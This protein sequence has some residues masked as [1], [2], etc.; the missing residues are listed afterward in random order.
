MRT[1]TGRA[2]GHLSSGPARSGR[3][4]PGHNIGMRKT[5]SSHS[6]QARMRRGPYCS[7][8]RPGSLGGR[9]GKYGKE[10]KV[11]CQMEFR[12]DFIEHKIHSE[13]AAYNNQ[14]RACARS[15][16]DKIKII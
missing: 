13:F 16:K 7:G 9:G 10:N 11:G 4:A 14:Y 8:H 3:A 6:Y 15:Q 12:A 5:R 1:D 2:R